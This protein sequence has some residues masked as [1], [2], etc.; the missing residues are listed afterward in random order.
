MHSQVYVRRSRGCWEIYGP[1]PDGS[2]VLGCVSA[3]KV[4]IQIKRAP[5]SPRESVIVSLLLVLHG[6]PK[7]ALRGFKGRESSSQPSPSSLVRL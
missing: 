2:R 7:R 5:L 6:D 1:A 3:F 4:T